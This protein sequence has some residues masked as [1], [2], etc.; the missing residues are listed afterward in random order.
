MSKKLD[1]ECFKKFP[2]KYDLVCYLTQEGINCHYSAD[3]ESMNR[4]LVD[5]AIDAVL[6]EDFDKEKSE[7]MI[8]FR[9][10]DK[11]KVFANSD[12]DRN[13]NEEKVEEIT[14]ENF[15]SEDI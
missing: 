1:L 8:A 10:S 3:D 14:F 12:E 13:E 6:K 5:R 7:K 4:N 11:D 9:F 2:N 15:I